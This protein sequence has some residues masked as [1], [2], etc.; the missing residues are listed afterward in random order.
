MYVARLRRAFLLRVHPD[1]F[2]SYPS[3]IRRQQA[4][5]VQ[6]LQDRLD[7]PDFLSYQYGRGG[8]AQHHVRSSVQKKAMK[9]VLEHE[10]DGDNK[11]EGSGLHQYTLNLRNG[12]VDILQDMRNALHRSSPRLQLPKPPPIVQ[13]A[14]ATA[15]SSTSSPIHWFYP[16]GAMDRLS[17]TGPQ[18]RQE[19]RERQEDRYAVRS[20][21]GRDLARFLE[22]VDAR[23]VSRRR[24][25]RMDVVALALVVRRLY[26]FASV[27]G[28]GLGWSSHNLAVLLRRGLVNLH[29]YHA[30]QLAVSSFYPLRLV[31]SCA[32]DNNQN[33]SSNS[34]NNESSADASSGEGPPPVDVYGGVL[35]LNPAYTNVQCLETLLR[36]TPA[37]LQEH[38]TLQ[39]ELNDNTRCVQDFLE[40]V[41]FRK[42]HSCSFFD[43]HTLLQR[44][45]H[46]LRSTMSLTASSNSSKTTALALERLWV[47]V[48]SAQSCRRAVVDT[49]TGHVRVGAGMTMEAIVDG[50]RRLSSKARER[51][52]DIQ[53][54]HT[55]YRET[56]QLVQESLGIPKVTTTEPPQR[57]MEALLR[58]LAFEE[59][60]QEQ[61]QRQRM[62]GHSL[63]IVGKGQLC[64]LGDDGS[65][66]IPTDWK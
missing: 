60:Q 65:F 66:V 57:A 1:R 36:I 29:Q 42:G 61:Q 49:R 62:A 5:L 2:R 51:S 39:Q 11:T 4:E 21:E 20:R 25:D 46:H 41:R 30:H 35:Y 54:E 55:A 40:G 31:W 7:E 37:T 10:E 33:A 32:D 18:Q 13:S 44:L 56:V 50:V 14:T 52:M 58:L 47:T 53:R 8:E 48:E 16:D 9:Y 59:A 27:D 19:E 3:E 26:K 63:T 64:H 17:V 22:S 38:R 23:E 34:N 43:Y 24:A 45:A 15:A 6:A 28:T 12:V